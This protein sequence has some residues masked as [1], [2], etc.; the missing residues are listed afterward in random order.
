[1]VNAP[2]VFT[3]M[4]RKLLKGLKGVENFMDDILIAS[5]TWEEHMSQ[6][7]EVLLRLRR[8]NITARPTKCQVGY[9]DLEFLGF[10][11]GENTKQP[12]KSKIERMLS[13]ARPK[14]KTEEYDG[15]KFPVKYASRKLSKCEQGYAT[16]EAECLAVVW[17]VQ[18]FQKYLYGN[19]FTIETDHQPLTFLQ[20]ARLK[21]SRVL[22]WAMVLQPYRYHIDYI[23]GRENVGVDYLSRV[24]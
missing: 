14:S 9:P 22:R 7:A 21:N 18:K 8:A 17:G 13:S 4:M 24:M 11:V 10:V 12:E 1:M 2:A 6:L 3:Q 23:P 5:E 20:E 15:Q 16:V 19:Q